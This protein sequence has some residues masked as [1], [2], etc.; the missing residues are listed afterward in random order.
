MRQPDPGRRIPSGYLRSAGWVRVLGGSPATLTFVVLFW[1]A[2]LLSGSVRS[3]PGSSLLP[4]VAA[5]S[6]SVPDHWWALLLAGFWER[7][8]AGYL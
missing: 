6:H 8:L 1:T 7:D 2:G 5:T 4:H 3:G